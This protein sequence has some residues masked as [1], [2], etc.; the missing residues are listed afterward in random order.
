MIGFKLTGK[1]IRQTQL[2]F[3]YKTKSYVFPFVVSHHQAVYEYKT[4]EN[5]QLIMQNYSRL[6]SKTCCSFCFWE[7]LRT[8]YRRILRGGTFARLWGLDIVTAHHTLMRQDK[9]YNTDIV[10]SLYLYI[11]IYIVKLS[12]DRPRWP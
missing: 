5:L 7:S 6:R 9:N 10:G 2:I 1:Y 8:S 12:R 4:D 3:W 11:Y